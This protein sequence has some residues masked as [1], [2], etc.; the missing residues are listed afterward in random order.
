MDLMEGYTTCLQAAEYITEAQGHNETSFDDL[1]SVACT[2]FI[3]AQRQ[4]VKIPAPRPA[5][6]KAEQRAEQPPPPPEQ[7]PEPEA[8]VDPDDDNLPF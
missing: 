4:G 6:A 5:E 7:P 2:L 3:Q 8:V 1:H